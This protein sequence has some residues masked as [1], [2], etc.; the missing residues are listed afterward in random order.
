MRYRNHLHKHTSE[1]LFR[2]Y[3]PFCTKKFRSVKCWSRHVNNNHQHLVEQSRQSLDAQPSSSSQPESDY[4]SAEFNSPNSDPRSQLNHAASAASV[5][6]RVGHFLV[7]CRIEHDLS[8][9][10]TVFLTDHLLQ[11]VKSAAQEAVRARGLPDLDE[12]TLASLPTVSA[13]SRFQTNH[14]I[15]RHT[16][17]FYPFVPPTTVFIGTS[18][19]GVAQTYQYISITD[20]LKQLVRHP[21]CAP[22]FCQTVSAGGAVSG[23]VQ[24][25]NSGTRFTGQ[26]DNCI[27]LS[28]FY[29]DFNIV[30]PLGNKV[31]RSKLGGIQFQILNFPLHLRGKPEHIY[32]AALFKSCYVKKY[33]W[34]IILA[35]LIGEL[36]GLASSGFTETICGKEVTFRVFLHQFTGDNLAVHAI[37]GFTESFSSTSPC[38]FCTISKSRLQTTFNESDVQLRTPEVYANQLKVL[39]DNN[40]SQELR[41]QFGINAKCHLDK[42]QPFCAVECF[43]PDAAHDILEGVVPY[44]IQ[45]VLQALVKEQKLLTLDQLNKQLEDIRNECKGGNVP[46]PIKLTNGKISIRQSMSESWLLLRLL[47]LLLGDFVCDGNPQYGILVELCRLVERIFACKFTRDDVFYLRWL[48]T[49]WLKEFKEIFPS[50]SL[51]PKFHFLVHYPTA[52]LRFGPPR[53]YWTIRHEGKHSLLKRAVAQSKNRINVCKSIADKHQ[54][55]LALKLS[56]DAYLQCDVV[57]QFRALPEDEQADLKRAYGCDHVLGSAVEVGGCEYKSG[58]AVV[59]DDDVYQFGVIEAVAVDNDVKLLLILLDSEYEAHRNI[60]HVRRGQIRKCVP[61]NT[62]KDHNPLQIWRL[63]QTECVVLKWYV[64]H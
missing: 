37:A 40:F 53:C 36:Q 38:R 32:L 2:A 48:V 28:L 19:K 55:S 39:E 18:D 33:G 22:L 24:D 49:T 20:Q 10:T 29:D 30:D 27:Y 6:N 50:F 16:R 5:R 44:T 15:D 31:S 21:N 59:L 57:T 4:L 26:G 34:E 58:F 63:G 23:L 45:A 47:P 1:P 43:P 12:S 54:K 17:D 7:S 46:Q 51:K 62:L 9:R 3:C 13:V 25:F 61:L 35:N 14:R 64:D 60:Y 56:A 42:I 11:F 8:Q 52:V 41:S